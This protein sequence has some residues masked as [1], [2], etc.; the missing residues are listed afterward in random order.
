VVLFQTDY[1]IRNIQN[2]GMPGPV[3]SRVFPDVSKDVGAFRNS[4]PTV[5]L[6]CL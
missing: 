3:R 2:S 5:L 4:S 1:L 6:Y